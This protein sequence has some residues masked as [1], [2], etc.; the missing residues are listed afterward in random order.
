MKKIEIWTFKTCPFCVKAKILLDNI[1]VDYEEHCVPYGDSALKTLEGQTGC[2]TLPQIFADG[3]FI[4]DCSQI[5]ALHDQDQ[6][7]ALLG[8]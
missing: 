3:E 8:A 7:M 4:G 6:L 5:H 2:D 1:G